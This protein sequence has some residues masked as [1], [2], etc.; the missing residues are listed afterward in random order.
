MSSPQSPRRDA[1]LRETFTRL[2]KGKTGRLPIEQFGIL[3]RAALNITPTDSWIKQCIGS[4]RKDFNI[5]ECVEML[6]SATTPPDKY[7]QEDVYSALKRF[8]R[9]GD[10]TISPR[11]LRYVLSGTGEPLPTEWTNNIIRAAPKQS[12]TGNIRITDFLRLV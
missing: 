2:D 9:I 1:A 6:D 10:G 12:G 4:N 11:T 7:Y 5:E 8:D 3:V